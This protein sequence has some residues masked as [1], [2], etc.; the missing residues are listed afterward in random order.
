[1]FPLRSTDDLKAPHEMLGKSGGYHMGSNNVKRI[2]QWWGDDPR[3][4]IGLALQPSGLIACD[5]DVSKNG[6][7]H[8]AE[9]EAQHGPLDRTAVAHTGGGGVHILFR[10]IDV[11]ARPPGQLARGVD[12]KYNGYLAVAP[13]KHASGLRY[14]WEAGRGLVSNAAFLSPIPAWCLLR[15]GREAA[16]GEPGEA[17]DWT[18]DVR[19]RLPD[20]SPEMVLRKL[21]AVPAA[22]EYWPWL[23]MGMSLHHYFRGEATGLDAWI[24]WSRKSLDFDPDECERK[25]QSFGE[26]TGNITGA[27]LLKQYKAVRDVAREQAAQPVEDDGLGEEDREDEAGDVTNGLFF[28][29]RNRG[30]LLYVAASKDWYMYVAGYW[31]PQARHLAIERAKDAASALLVIAKAGL[32]DAAEAA[33]AA[34]AGEIAKAVLAG[35]RGRYADAKATYASVRRLDA[36]LIAASTLDGMRVSDPS[37][38]DVDPMLLG[39]ANGV[40]DLRTGELR[41]LVPEDRMTKRC[42]PAYN[43]KARCPRF[44]RFLATTF[45]GDQALISYIRRALGYT[46]TGRVTEEALF[47]MHGGGSNGK[48]VLVNIVSTIMQDYATTTGSDILRR[49]R[50]EG[51]LERYTVPLIGARMVLVNEIAKSEFWDDR[52]TKELVSTEPLPARMLYAEAIKFLP[53]H[54]FWVRGNHKPAIGDESQGLWRRMHLVGFVHEVREGEKNLDLAAQLIEREAEGI[55]AWMVAGCLEWQAGGLQRP[56]SVQA[57]TD[58][59]R[60]ESD[61]VGR[62]IKDCC[63]LDD[64]GKLE[65]AEA[66]SNYRAWCVAEGIRAIEEKNT[67]AK[68]ITSRSY[69]RRFRTDATRGYKGLR[70]REAQEPFDD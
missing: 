51:A 61:R 38:F 15:P 58:R 5:G 60:A 26:G 43:P 62:W 57:D 66:Y 39:V 55:L 50:N 2:K 3:A 8:L 65:T 63:V 42:L 49:S 10:A 31:T 18:A 14:R 21:G 69:I 46:L 13:S 33:E 17:D 64:N 67:F 9:L 25:W 34:E 47:F 23:H 20:H 28:A 32:R 41:P 27:Y 52:R 68:D 48:S 54:K 53:T 1:M 35:A 24:E 36:M 56:A 40:V 37:Q 16:V 59:F 19:D 30:R 45:S 44:L 29:Q 70:L 7:V 22:D 4:N 6:L 11:P 12:L